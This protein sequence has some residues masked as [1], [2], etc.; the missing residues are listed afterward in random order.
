M[1]R[2]TFYILIS[3]TLRS[4][5]NFKWNPLTGC[6]FFWTRA[7]PTNKFLEQC[8]CMETSWVIEEEVA[9]SR[10]ICLKSQGSCFFHSFPHTL[11]VLWMNKIWRWF[12]AWNVPSPTSLNFLRTEILTESCRHD[13]HRAPQHLS[14]SSHLGGTVKVLSSWCSLQHSSLPWSLRISNLHLEMSCYLPMI[15]NEFRRRT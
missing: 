14:Y 15:P 10:A 13:S 6:F 9:G 4:T 11:R 1:L 3:T 8:M 2:N 5:I 7:E 12:I